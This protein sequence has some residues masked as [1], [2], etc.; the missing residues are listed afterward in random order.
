MNKYVIVAMAL[1][2]IVVSVEAASFGPD[3]DEIFDSIE[4]MIKVITTSPV[5]EWVFRDD[6]N[7][8]NSDEDAYAFTGFGKNL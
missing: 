2:A 6:D 5:P 3:M 4:D 1:V 7:S 8:E